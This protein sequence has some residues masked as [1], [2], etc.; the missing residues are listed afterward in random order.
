MFAMMILL[1]T[2]GINDCKCL[3]FLFFSISKKIS[4][5][6]YA[7]DSLIS[8]QSYMIP[9]KKHVMRGAIDSYKQNSGS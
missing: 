4:G 7:L 5:T 1:R 3:K 2:L 9:M 8:S 6:L